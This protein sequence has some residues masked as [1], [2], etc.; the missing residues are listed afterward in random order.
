MRLTVVC[1]MATLFS[2][3]V[4]SLLSAQLFGTVNFDFDSDQLDAQARQKVAEIAE[5]LKSVDTYKPTVIVGYT[6][7]VGGNS[8]NNNL[9]LRRAQAVAN[10]LRASG[11]P[12]ERVGKTETRG[13]NELLVAVTTPERANRRVTVG[14]EDILAA[15]RSYREIP[16]S[17][18]DVGDAL[19][20][21]LVTRV[22]E[23]AGY[24]SQLTSNGANGSAFQMAGAA[25]EDCEQA[26][27]FNRDAIRKVEYAKKCFCSSAR[28]KVALGLI[29]AN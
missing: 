23:A 27:G 18:A 19:Q 3:L 16:L 17:T 25:R 24:Y 20:N 12:V 1:L 22:S 14:L 11:V 2:I 21:D 4:P 6:D 28:M 26:V 15:C 5:A 8:Y 9:G 29:P 7:A 13:K 10:A